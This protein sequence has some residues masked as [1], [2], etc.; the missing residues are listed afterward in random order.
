MRALEPRIVLDAAIA[1]TVED[2]VNSTVH[3]DFADAY[4]A[5]NQ[6][7]GNERLSLSDLDEAPL[8]YEFQTDIQSASIPKSLVFIDSRVENFD[9]LAASLPEGAHA[10]I[11]DANADGLGEITSVLSE[12][13]DVESIHI[14]S[15][16]RPGELMLGNTVLTLD[17]LTSIQS[18]Q[19]QI[20]G[21]SLDSDADILIYGC[22]FGAGARGEAASK[23]LSELTGADVASST[24]VTGHISLGGDWD[25]ESHVGQ[26][27]EQVVFTATFQEQWV[28]KLVTVTVDTTSDSNDA[29]GTGIV[30]GNLSHDISWLNANVGAD[31]RISM[32]EAIIAANNTVGVDTINFNI[33]GTGPH[34]I[35]L[36]TALP[37]ITDTVLLDGWSEPDFVAGS[38]VIE[39]NGLGAGFGATGLTFNGT[40]S[41]STV[42]GL[43]INNFGGAG[44]L[45]PA[46]VNNITISGNFIGTDVTGTSAASNGDNGITIYSDNNVIGGITLAERNVISGNGGNGITLTGVNATDN[47]ILNNHIG[48][49][50]TGT[51][52]LG[53]SLSGVYV[54]GGP[55]GNIIG[56]DGDG[57][58]DASEGNLISGN[59]LHGV[60]IY[61]AG[62]D[63]NIIAGNRIGTD[64]TG[65]LALGNSE[66]GV[67]ILDGAASNIIG[68]TSS[69]ECNIIA[70]NGDD[71]VEIRDAGSDGNS[72]VG[73]S[74]GLAGD[75]TTLLGNFDNGVAIH[76]SASGNIIGG[77]VAGSRNV[78][79]GGEEGVLITGTG[80]TGNAV[81]GNYIGTDVTGLVAAGFS[82][83]AIQISDGASGNTI[84]GTTAAHRNIIGGASD[85][86]IQISSSG[87]D[88]NTCPR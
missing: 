42:R 44:I 2:V 3:T 60:Q 50:V 65:M 22:D 61:Q 43:V 54:Q 24:D 27:E 13:S 41:G 62:S 37:Q 47:W 12:L 31:G 9:F 64:A 67:N 46:T 32:R 83:D 15:H 75:G 11:L 5:N 39:L 52:D 78:I 20:I 23:I 16:G 18:Q 6:P 86:G 33:A 38:P 17:S 29:G 87:A 66:D 68:G 25:L 34:I 84:G 35:N 81:S 88:N 14:I 71:G 4:A 30:D 7:S 10:V 56:T 53:N 57:S 21:G 63:S 85:D 40:S 77:T 49:D 45:V 59:T 55:S 19:L 82:D 36:G 51:V 80:T 1:E 72:V 58:N 79:A 74:I 69:D 73:N 70:G 26:I 48:T 76:S 8:S 28:G